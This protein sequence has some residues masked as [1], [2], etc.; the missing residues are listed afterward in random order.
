MVMLA[1]VCTMQYITW[2][3]LAS[4]RAVLPWTL[5]AIF[6]HVGFF[7]VI[8]SGWSERFIDPA[9]TMAQMAYAIACCANGYAIAGAVRS[10][11]LSRE[12]LR[13][14][15]DWHGFGFKLETVLKTYSD[16]GRA[17]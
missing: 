6:G 7:A 16:K 17:A 5:A 14:V 10:A 3:G 11:S 13:V 1:G 8:R 2:A 15:S 12:K 4:W 9:M